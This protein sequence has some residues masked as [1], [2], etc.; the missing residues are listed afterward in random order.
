[1]KK[2]GTRGALA[3]VL[4]MWMLGIGLAAGVE[5]RLAEPIQVVGTCGR[6]VLLD[7]GGQRVF[8]M[9]GTPYEM[10]YQQ[11]KLL[12]SECRSLIENILRLTRAAEASGA[13]EFLKNGSFEEALSRSGAFIDRRFYEEMKGLSDGA[14]IPFQEVVLANIFPEL[15]HCSGFALFGKA[16]DGGELLHGRILDY[17]TEAGLQDYAVVTVAKPDGF[18]A[19]VSVGYAGFVG[20][21]TGMNAEQIGLGE[22]GGRGEGDW[23]GMP[24]SFLMRKVLEEADTLQQA[25]SIFEKTPRTCEYYYVVSDARANDARGLACWPDRMLT[26][27][28]GR[29]YE[30]LPEAIDDGVLMSAGDRYQH[31]ARRVKEAYGAIDVAAALALMDRP[32]AMESCLHRVLFSPKSGQFWVA[33]AAAMG[34]G[35]YQA[36]YQPYYKF[37]FNRLLAMI[38]EENAGQTEP[39]VVPKDL[40]TLAIPEPRRETP[41]TNEKDR[42][43][44]VDRTAIRKMTPAGNERQKTLLAGYAEDEK[45]FSYTMTCMNTASSYTIYEVSFPSGAV[46]KF[47]ENNTVY[48]EYYKSGADGKRPAV[49]LLDILNGSM[50]ISRILAHSLADQGTDAC[51]MTLPYYGKRKPQN[52]DERTITNEGLPFFVDAIRQGVADVRRT[53][54]WLAAQEVVDRDRIGICGT[55]LGGFAAALSAGVDGE[56]SRAAFL[57][58]GGDLATVLTSGEKEVRG[59]KSEIDKRG[60][61][62]EQLEEWLSVIE[63]LN[64]ADRLTK[65]G[66]LMVNGT[67]DPIVNAECA[68]KLA[69]RTGAQMEWYPTDHYG[70][71]KYLIPVTA[72]ICDHFSSRNW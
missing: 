34:D 20:T 48:C 19:F 27:E 14:G 12:G 37:D 26:F 3:V 68:K 21:V 17:M 66:I 57:L 50:I 22:M 35:Q 61:D 56:F 11:G 40:Q 33:N 4:V 72:R 16:T 41:G 5:V 42:V 70:M 9:A 54:R 24:M 32:I 39:I 49:I 63:P 62:K 46:S 25:V 59:L 6:G 58:A 10:G 52:A 53:A 28:P 71:A 43:G 45:D 8:L 18:N 47:D 13:K 64:F 38:P 23:D 29:E 2:H 55:S 31:L 44:V 67:L 51:I 69:D 7:A 30:R 1:M 65:T 15:F 60:I 36:C